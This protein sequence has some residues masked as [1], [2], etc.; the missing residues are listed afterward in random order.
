M[1]GFCLHFFTWEFQLGLS[2][3]SPYFSP[4]YPSHVRLI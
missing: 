4:P 1:P 2:W 3:I